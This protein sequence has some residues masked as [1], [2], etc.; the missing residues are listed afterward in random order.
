MYVNMVNAKRFARN[1]M[2]A[3]FV[4]INNNAINA[5]DVH[6]LLPVST[7]KRFP[8][9]VPNGNPI[10]FDAT[11]YSTQTPSFRENTN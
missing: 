10:V 6:R 8:Y 3:I 1:V 5:S 4:L 7:A 2:E 11:V 9:Y